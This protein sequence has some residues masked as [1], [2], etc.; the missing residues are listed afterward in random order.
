MKIINRISYFLLAVLSLIL[1][2][3]CREEIIPPNSPL[4]NLNEPVRLV[5]NGTYTFILNA[6]DISATYKDYSGLSGIHS[7]VNI[8]LDNYTGGT[9]IFH[10]YNNSEQLI[11]QKSMSDNIEEFSQHL[12]NEYPSMVHIIFNDFSGKLKI[13]VDNW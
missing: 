7:I 8:S 11:F 1:F 13:V 2:D 10:I 9:V 12:D 4:T 5:S 3:S 6:N